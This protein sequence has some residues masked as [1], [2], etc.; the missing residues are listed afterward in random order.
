MIQKKQQLKQL[1]E[2]WSIMDFQLK[3]VYK[4][5]FV[6]KMKKKIDKNK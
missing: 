5:D 1:K 4:N 3:Q 2:D 6:L